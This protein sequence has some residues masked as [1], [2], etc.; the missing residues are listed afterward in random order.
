MRACPSERLKNREPDVKKHQGLAQPYFA[1]VDLLNLLD[2]N[3]LRP[4]RLVAKLRA[5]LGYER[6]F[7]MSATSAS[8]ADEVRRWHERSHFRNFFDRGRQSCPDSSV[9]N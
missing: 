5:T 8:S 3:I 2:Q 6:R 4:V 9:I 1:A 7:I